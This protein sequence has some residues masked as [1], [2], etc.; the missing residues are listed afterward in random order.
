MTGVPEAFARTT[1]D[2]EGAQAQA[3]LD[4]LPGLVENLLARWECTVDGQLL[5]GGIALIVPVRRRAD[6]GA[7]VLKVSFPHPGNRHEPHALAAWQGRGA[8]RLY[9]RDDSSFAMLLEELQPVTLAQTEEGEHVAS[10]AGALNHLLAVPAPADMPQLQQEAA[11]WEQRLR[12]DDAALGHPLSAHVVGTA[13]S[14]LEDLAQQQPSLMVHGDLHGRNILRADREPWLAVDP[15]GFAGDPAYDAGTLLK[16]RLP[17]FLDTQNLAADVH[18]ILDA[19]A[20]AAQLDRTRVRRWA[21]LH[22]VQAAFGGRRHGFRR[23]RGGPELQRLTALMDRTAE[24]LTAS[25]R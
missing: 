6:G 5:H 24:A 15:K 12:A 8:V 18:R 11:A 9:E 16:S 21:Q 3:W 7:A 13:L 17:T 19:F 25:P 22:A 14:T 1:L 10:V 20:E 23:A 2:R 4:S